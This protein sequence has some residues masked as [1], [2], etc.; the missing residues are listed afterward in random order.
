[1]IIVLTKYYSDFNNVFYVTGFGYLC[2]RAGQILL[3]KN[4]NRTL[5]LKPFHFLLLA[6][7]FLATLGNLK[8]QKAEYY[9]ISGHV[10]DKSSGELLPG[11]TIFVKELKTGSVSNSYGFY[12][13]TLP[14]G[15]YHLVYS[16]VGYQSQIVVIGLRH[17]TL[18]N[19]ELS[20][21][22]SRLQEVEIKSESARENI[23]L[24]QMSVTKMSIRNI[25]EIPSFMGE[26]DLIKALQLLPGVKFVAEGSSGMSVRGG[27]PDQN[28]I[29]LD[30]ATVY[31]AGHL[32][33]F[34]S[35]F[36][37]DAV[38]SV[39]LYKNDMPAA[40]GGRISSLVEVRMKEGNNKVFQ[41]QG[42][43]GLISSRIM[44][45]GPIVKNKASFMISGRRTYADLFLK[46]SHNAKLRQN[47]LYFYDLNTKLNFALNSNNHFYLSGYFG[48]DV[49]KNDFF[50]MDWG[51]ATGTFRWNHIYNERLFSNASV[52]VSRYNYNLGL[53]ED[54]PRAFLWKSALT[55]FML[56]D[57]FDWF[58]N[59]ENKLNFGFSIIYHDFFPGKIIGT[60][61]EALIDEYRL[62]DNYALESAFYVSNEQKIGK[63]TLKYGLRVS[64]FN[65]LGPATIYHYD[66]QFRVVDS[67]IY[68]SKKVFNTY[69]GVEP[70]LG[71]VFRV[72]KNSSIKASYSRNYQYIQQAQNSTAGNPMDIW[73]P[74]NPNIKP[75]VGDQVAAGYY[76]DFKHSM[77]SFSAELYYKWLH[78][79][80]DFKDHA[81]LLL[82]K[83]LDGELRTG[84][85]YSYGLEL[86]LKKSFGKLTGWGS[87]TWSRS[88]RVIPEINKGVAY[89]SSYDRPNDFSLTMSYRFSKKLRL[90][91]SWVYLTG[92]P[93]TFPVSR[94]QYSHTIVPVYSGRNSYRM[95]DYHRMD[96]AL[97]WDMHNKKLKKGHNQLNF[98]IYNVY[99]RKNPWVINFQN[100]PKVPNSTYAEMTYLFGIVP[101]VTYNF[102]F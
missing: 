52:I 69:F 29:L 91:M 55:D 95:A 97:I 32:M 84:R 59:P 58:I 96:L 33:G 71:I 86:M 20:A 99:N 6:L 8:A 45:E 50:G 22:S 90:S 9:T 25:A 100:D 23:R 83:Y 78:N 39:K 43:I 74:A 12:S 18:V 57:N 36:N 37:P 82:N 87:Y 10:R 2:R 68:D 62:P 66:R 64:I 70:R 38:Q 14:K 13:L 27:S 53:A 30:G 85:G 1:M 19:K 42:G 5:F 73:F 77:F 28:L 17:D 56:K 35:V 75:Q 79:A 67:T 63:I 101:T 11:A 44:F 51:N 34:F 76:H 4:M 81:N 47:R 89:P 41:V 26:V 92:Q 15:N 60:G 40:Y 46:L 88:L 65:N 54:D 24:P 31:N 49:F 21:V 94:F 93:V 98:S 102:K 80:V 72:N 7:F 16:F 61:K 48:K 3:V